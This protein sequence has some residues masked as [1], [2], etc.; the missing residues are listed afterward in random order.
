MVKK[1]K[2]KMSIE[3]QRAQRLD[4]QLIY[5]NKRKTLGITVR[6]GEVIVRAPVGMKRAEVE[7]AVEKHLYWINNSLQR[8]RERAEK[9]PEPSLSEEK[10]L[11]ADAKVYFGDK[12]RHFS[13]ITGI[14]YGRMTITGAKKRFGSC[15][16]RG[17]ICFSYRLMLYPEAFREYVVLHEL[18]HRVYMNHSAKFYNLISKYMPDYKERKR[19]AK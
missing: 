17:D 6:E 8:Q 1:L 15:N 19:L 18:C 14:N 5:S 16:T 9:F 11:R 10:A 12:L 4:Y 7:K 3:K 2:V 13:E